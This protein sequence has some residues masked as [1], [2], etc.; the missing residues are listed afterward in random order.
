MML[1]NEFM[2]QCPLH[3][4]RQRQRWQST[5]FL[6]L[7]FD[8][9][10]LPVP[11]FYTIFISCRPQIL[12]AERC[13]LHTLGFQLTVQHPYSAVMCLLRKLFA[14]G[15]GAD[16][17]KGVNKALNRQ[18][19]QARRCLSV[20]NLNPFCRLVRTVHDAVQMLEIV[21]CMLDEVLIAVVDFHLQTTWRV[22][23]WVRSTLATSNTL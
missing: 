11:S 12:I 6:L 16:G 4:Y 23:P 18:L 15:R 10:S 2:L 22:P 21:A 14:Q 17:G 9:S 8:F 5:L 7:I 19:N 20:Q 1:S 3:F 13:V